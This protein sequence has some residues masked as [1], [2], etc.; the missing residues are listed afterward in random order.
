VD[1]ESL[2]CAYADPTFDIARMYGVPDD[3]VRTAEQHYCRDRARSLMR[4]EVSAAVL[5]GVVLTGLTVF[6][7]RPRKVT[8]H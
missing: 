8:V 5:T 7:W 2:A 3:S 4:F 1:D 6:A